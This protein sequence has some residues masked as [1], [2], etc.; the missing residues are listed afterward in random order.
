G[1][2]QARADRAKDYLVNTRGIDAG[3]L[4]TVDG[5]CRS[6]L[7]V[8]LWVVP[9]GATPPAASM[10]NIISPCPDCKQPKPRYPRRRGRRDEE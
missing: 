3:R 1:E 5:G 6:D 10:D 7:A 4:T 9:T 8:E 2:A